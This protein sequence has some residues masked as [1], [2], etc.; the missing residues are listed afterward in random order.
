M[1]KVKDWLQQKKYDAWQFSPMLR[2]S[3]RGGAI[4]DV[5]R[6]RDNK[7][8]SLKTSQYIDGNEYVIRHFSDDRIH[9][10]CDVYEG[11]NKYIRYIE[12]NDLR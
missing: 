5:V 2:I 6:N 11:A 10:D 8:F 4:T 12:I 9:V 3:G 1:L 7:W